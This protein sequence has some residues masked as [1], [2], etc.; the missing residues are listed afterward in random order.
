TAPTTAGPA[1]WQVQPR[2]GT[3]GTLTNLGS[4]PSIN[5]YD[6]NTAGSISQTA[7]PSNVASGVAIGSAIT[8][9]FTAGAGG[10]SG[11]SLGITVPSGWTAPRTTAGAGFTA[12][13]TGTL[14]VSGQQIQVTGLTLAAG[15]TMTVTYGSGG[16]GNLPVAGTTAGANTFG[17]VKHSTAS[18]GSAVATTSQPAAINVYAADGSGTIGVAPTSAVAGLTGNTHT[19]TYTAATGGIAGGSV[20]LTV[21]SGWTAPQTA[22]A[23]S[24]G[25]TTASGG[26]GANTIAWN[27]GTRKLTVSGVTLAAAATLTITY[28]ANAGSG[29]GAAAPTS[30]GAGSTWSTQQKSTSGGTLTSVGT[31]PDVTIAPGSLSDFLVEAA[32]G[33]A[34]GSQTAGSSFSIRVTARDA[35]GNTVTGFNGAGNTV[36]LT[37]TGTLS[38]G[39]GATGTFTNGVLASHNVTITSSGSRTLTATRT[40]GG[41]QT[42]TSSAFTVAPTAAVSLDVAAPGS[43]TAGIPFSVDVTARDT[44]GNVASGYLGT[45]AFSGGGTGAQLPGNYS[46]A[47]GDAGAKTFSGVELR[48][49]GSRTV[50]VT[51]TVTGSITGNDSVTVAPGAASL[52]VSTVSAAPTS[53]AAN[54]S[55]TSTVTLRLKD[56]FGN[57]LPAG[58]GATYAFSTDRGSVGAATDN[59]DGT[60][61]ATLTSST[62]A[63]TATVSATRNAAAFSATAAV[64]FAPGPGVVLEVAAPA[65]TTAGGQFAVTVTA[66]DVNGNTA[67]GYTGTIAFSGGG[68]GA[69]LPTN[70]TFVPGDAGTKTFAPVELRQ[71]GSRTITATDTVTGSITGGDTLTV[72]HAPAASLDVAVPANGITGQSFSATVTAKDAY[73]NVATGYLGTVTFSTT[74]GGGSV[75]ADYTFV[76]GDNGTATVAGFSFSTPGSKS[77]VATD[78]VTG[79]VTGSGPITVSTAGASLATSTFGA[80]PTSILANG[81]STSTITLQLKD[82]I[83]NNLV[84]GDGASYVFNTSGGSVGSGTDNGDGTVTATLTS[85]TSAGVATV[86][87]TR[88]GSPFANSVSVTFSPGAATTLEVSAPAMATA[89]T[90]FSVDVT[91]RDA[92]GNVATGYLGTVSFS[93]GGTGA[94]LPASYTFVSGDAGTKTFASVEL[95]QAGSRTITATDTV[96]GSITGADTL[97]V[98][99]GSATQIALTSSTADLTSGAARVLTAT[100][101]DAWGNTVTSDSSTVVAFAKASGAGTVS[102]GG[103]ATASGGVAAKTITGVLA[104]S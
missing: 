57:D 29:G 90:P 27:G 26:S 95:R 49:A 37:S 40:S 23:T 65:T 73:A 52:S 74:G 38:A 100:V 60:Y 55:S 101:Q 92:F 18:I 68:T 85:S 30:T 69:Q 9:T 1:T 94:Q 19:F 93:G 47:G 45:V 46:F 78:T 39:G 24:A 17:A 41:V 42:G 72:N 35:F 12:A 5:V 70:Y 34:I 98:G 43:A 97:T 82:A 51:D 15:A 53:I 104:G 88:D 54:G 28:G 14:G 6:A 10:M 76:A 79:S 4:S 64:T 102:G 62:S 83:G 21:P 63:G 86:S 22:S 48:Q 16:G 31:S 99:H 103:N 2:S 58:D 3:G 36:D 84:V 81:S 20:E 7:G 32:G 91:A 89:G 56:A 61:S 67:T 59:G 50:T 13:T 77:V 11:G 33:G 71:A 75:P 87:A 80:S 44:Y 96:T 66:K 25:Y 8:W